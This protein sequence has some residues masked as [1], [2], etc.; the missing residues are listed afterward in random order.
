MNCPNCNQPLQDDPNN[1]GKVLCYSCRKRFDK[2][3]VEAYWS[4][5]QPMQ[6]APAPAMQQP[7]PQA[8][9]QPQTP[10]YGAAPTPAYNP[11]AP[12]YGAAP[13]QKLP[14]GMAI[15]ALV[16]GI[17]A[18]LN[19]WI[20]MV[21]VIAIIFGI[22]ALILGIIG[23]GKAK[24]GLA[25]GKGLAL[26]GVITGALGIVFSIAITVLFVIGLNSVMDESGITYEDLA[27][28]IENSQNIELDEEFTYSNDESESTDKTVYNDNASWTSLSFKLGGQDFR[29]GE[30][31]LAQLEASGWVLD[32]AAQ[33]YPDGY[34]VEAQ[35][36]ISVINLEHPGSDASVYVNVANL[37]NEPKSIKD[38]V[39]SKISFDTYGEPSDMF[40]IDG[41]Q[42]GA[43]PEDVKAKFG[44]PQD[45]YGEATD[46]LNWSYETS[47]Y[48]KYMD[49]TFT[50]NTLSEISITSLDY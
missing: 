11:N 22:V 38:C 43:T 37:G 17:L 25:G 5:Q 31:T 33:G 6:A 9:T 50:N 24:K 30:T 41:I 32:L 7:A 20:P 39:V 15:A 2:S 12:M 4:A 26:G 47:D 45:V 44:D 21:N 36:M 18:V 40:A 23:M 48:S 10:T 29:L 8:P 46:Y 34:D 13:V 35:Q 19:C 3:K 16:L 28:E 42:C 27:N 14:K 1:P 49:L